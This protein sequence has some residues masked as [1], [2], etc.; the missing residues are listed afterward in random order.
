MKERTKALIAVGLGTLVGL[1]PW[2]D[3]IL[4]NILI[5]LGKHD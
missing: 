3:S 1:S 5:A 4:V 2:R